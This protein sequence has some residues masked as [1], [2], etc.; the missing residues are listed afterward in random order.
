MGGTSSPA[1]TTQAL[2]LWAVALTAGV[3]LTAQHIIPGIQNLVADT[4]FRQIETRTEW[5]SDRKIFP[6]RI[7]EILHQVPK[8]VSGCGCI[9]SALEQMNL[10]NPSSRSPSA[11]GTEE[12]QRGSSNCSPPNCPELYRTAMV[13]RSH[14]D[15][16]GSPTAATPA[17][18]YVVSP[19]SANSIPSPVEV[20]LSDILATIRN[21][22]QAT[23]LSKR[24]FKQ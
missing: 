21:R 24:H 3:S 17:P 19:N 14:S 15:A 6:V 9:P 5:T 11:S 1:P 7:S 13:P 18:I 22:Y 20:P 10:S 23:G 16:S 8:Y 12:D 4:A 2:E